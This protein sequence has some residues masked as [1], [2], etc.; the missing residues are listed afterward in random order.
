MG[1][2]PMVLDR[3]AGIPLDPAWIGP[4]RGT[5]LRN[6]T[7]WLFVASAALYATSIWLYQNDR[8]PYALFLL[9]NCLSLYLAYTVLH[10]G[11]HGCLHRNR[12]VSAVLAR[13]C[14]AMLVFSYPLFRAVHLAHHH[15]PNTSADP[16]AIVRRPKV[17]GALLGG[18]LIFFNYYIV[19]YTRLGWRDRRSLVETAVTHAF[20]IAV[21]VA[22][23]AHGWFLALFFASIVPLLITL[24]FL[25]L[26]FDFVPHH[27]HDTSERFHSTRAYGG[28]LLNLLLLGQNFHLIHHL[29]PRI[30]WYRYQ[31][32]FGQT[33][34]H[35]IEHGCRIGRDSRSPS[36][37]QAEGLTRK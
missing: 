16:D 11:V 30:P 29:W 24:W 9:L 26:F 2:H 28:K 17:V 31:R 19:F 15:E 5:S 8:A 4:P 14:G 32:V 13:V 33:R 35:L 37:F 10:E 20:Q 27:P 36:A 7:L 3:R 21:I 18:L 1:E 22:A 23:I 12:I 34:T 25:V 6:P